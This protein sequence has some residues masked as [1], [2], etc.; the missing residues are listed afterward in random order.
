MGMTANEKLNAA[1]IDALEIIKY[2]DPRLEEIS[3]PIDDV[4]ANSDRLRALIEKMAELMF[5]FNGVG[6][7]AAQVGLTVRLFL[8]CPTFEPDDL[9]VYINPKIVDYQGAEVREEGCLSFPGIFAKIKR[10]AKV[11]MRAAGLDGKEFTTA[12]DG[13]HG[14]ICLHEIDHLEGSLLVDRMS[15]LAK[16]ANRKALQELEN[17]QIGK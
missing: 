13:L 1:D 8:A 9:H 15:S 11:T 5:D 6:L 3:T 7:A 2:P 12:C 17:R 10:P 4:Q 16:L 14:R